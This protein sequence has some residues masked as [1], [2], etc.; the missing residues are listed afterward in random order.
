MSGDLPR[1]RHLWAGNIRST[2]RAPRKKNYGFGVGAYVQGGVGGVGAGVGIGVC[3]KQSPIALHWQ[4]PPW[5]LHQPYGHALPMVTVVE[6][7]AQPYLK[8]ISCAL[9][10]RFIFLN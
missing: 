9:N 10:G 7:V 8:G 4:P 6:L 5:H 2:R 1:S 3:A